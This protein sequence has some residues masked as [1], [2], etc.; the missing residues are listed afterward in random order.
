MKGQMKGRMVDR[1]L[2]SRLIRPL[3]AGACALALTAA[4]PG[5]ASA[6]VVGATGSCSIDATWSLRA[7]PQDGVIWVKYTVQ[8]AA[9]G[10]VWRVRL[11]HDGVLVFADLRVTGDDGS[12]TVRRPMR[13]RPRADLIRARAYH[14][15]T[16]EVCTGAIAV[17]PG[18]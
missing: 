1:M 14:R 11:R 10:E 18:A 8:S 9:P 7:S 4:A 2:R 5:P 16:G 13:D 12:F 17:L 15:A 3:L 6:T